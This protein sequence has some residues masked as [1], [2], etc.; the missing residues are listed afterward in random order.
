MKYNYTFII[1]Q[2]NNYDAT[3]DFLYCNK[4]I[5]IRFKSTVAS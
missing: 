5:K 2:Y 4:D 1:S 3:V